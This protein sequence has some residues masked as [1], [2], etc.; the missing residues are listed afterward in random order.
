MLKKEE[1]NAIEMYLPYVPIIGFF[2]YREIGPLG[3]DNRAKLHNETF[4]NF[5]KGEE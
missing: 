2:T 4:F 5:L 3:R 1:F